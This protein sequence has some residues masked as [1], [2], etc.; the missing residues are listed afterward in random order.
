VLRELLG[1]PLVDAFLA[2]RR[3]EQRAFDDWWR[4]SV[5][6]WELARYPRHI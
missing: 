4:T 3:T 6:E 1:S 2:T 5:S